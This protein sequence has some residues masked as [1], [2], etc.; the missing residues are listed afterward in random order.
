VPLMRMHNHV[1]DTGRL[2]HIDDYTSEQRL[3]LT[4]RKKGDAHAFML[5]ACMHPILNQ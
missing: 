4:E 5:R 2:V 1:T 3:D